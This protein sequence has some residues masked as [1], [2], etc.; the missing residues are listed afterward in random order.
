VKRIGSEWP[1]TGIPFEPL[2]TRLF[3]GASYASA[4]RYP[5]GDHDVIDIGLHVIKQCGMYSEEYKNWIARENETPPIV[6]KIDSFKEYWADR[7]TLVNQTAA[8]AWQHGYDMAAMD[9]DASIASHI[10]SLANFGAVYA[11]TQES[12]KAQA[13]TMTAMQGQ[14]TNIQQFC[15]AVA[16]QP[17]PNIY[18]PSQQ[19][20]TF[21]NCRNRRNGGGHGNGSTSGNSGGG[22]GNFPQQPTWFGGNSAGTQQPTRPPTPYKH[23]EN[24]NCCH[25]HGGD[26]DDTHMST[27]C[28]NRGPTHNANATRANIMGGLIAGMHKTILP[29]AC[30]HIPSPPHR[31]QQQ[32]RP[33]QHPPVAY[34][35]VQGMT[36]PMYRAR[37]TMPIPVHQP[38]QGMMIFVGQQ[39]PA[40]NA[41]N[42]Q[43]M[44]QPAQQAMPMMAPYYAPN[45]QP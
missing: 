12:M 11:A 3:I 26:V 24:W 43:M 16:Q 39:Y 4:A 36:Q 6:E 31:P 17:P 7:I 14:L 30:G 22:G 20:P 15:L 42:A 35:P 18:I 10:E 13:T 21:N 27:S 28:G 37:T 25:T 41:A 34:Y 23:W 33:Q 29:S 8:P 2:A 40:P 44:Q 32:Q 1:P 19:Q 38:G 45:Q 5:M 9:D